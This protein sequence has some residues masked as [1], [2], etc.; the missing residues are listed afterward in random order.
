[1]SATYL[2]WCSF[3]GRPGGALGMPVKHSAQLATDSDVQWQQVHTKAAPSHTCSPIYHPL[4]AP[5]VHD[6]EQHCNES[7]L[8][9]LLGLGRRLRRL[10]GK[11]QRLVMLT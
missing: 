6:P 9:Q 7:V 3:V 11:L 8:R 2:A 5:A 4:L 1:M 10:Q